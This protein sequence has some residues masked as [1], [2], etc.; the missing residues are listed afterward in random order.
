MDLGVDS[1]DKPIFIDFD[2]MSKITAS[3]V[4]TAF[5]MIFT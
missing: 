5:R 4:P 3:S 2:P 1:P